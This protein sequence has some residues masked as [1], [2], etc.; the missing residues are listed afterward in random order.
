MRVAK[1]KEKPWGLWT[2]QALAV[3]RLE[4]RKRLSF[5]HSETQISSNKSV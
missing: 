3:L 2:R 1:L 4:A 5:T